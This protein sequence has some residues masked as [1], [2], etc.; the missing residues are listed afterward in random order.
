[1]IAAA[2]AVPL[3]ILMS[4]NDY[5]HRA[6]R[7]IVEFLRPVP[8]VAL[9]P[10]AILLFGVGFESKV[11]LVAFASLWPLLV[12]TLAG[13]RDVDPAAL[14]TAAVYRIPRAHRILRVVVPSALP[15]VATGLRIASTTALIVALVAELVI[16][17]P[18]L[19]Q[20]ITLAQAANAVALMYALIISTGLLGLGLNALFLR[21]ERAVLHW[22]PAHREVTA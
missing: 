4:G 5:V 19:G 8:S 3:A 12:Q 2:I 15:Y 9:I 22:H 14:T 21:I 1:L 7:T 18:G 20:A 6:L 13:L 11:F 17:A 16:G 10:V